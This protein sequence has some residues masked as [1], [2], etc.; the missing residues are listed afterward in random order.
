MI[1]L[2]ENVICLYTH[3]HTLGVGWHITPNGSLAGSAGQVV[4]PSF[5]PIMPP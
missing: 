2:H 4:M 1:Y 5:I 3:K